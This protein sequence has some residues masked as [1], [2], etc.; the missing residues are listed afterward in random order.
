ML[1]GYTQVTESPHRPFLPNGSLPAFQ[2]DLAS[3]LLARGP[4]AW[5][6]SG[7]EGCHDR[8]YYDGGMPYNITMRPEGL[9]VDYGTPIDEHCID[10]DRLEQQQQQQQE[11]EAGSAGSADHASVTFEGSITTPSSSSS[12]SGGSMAPPSCVGYEVT[13]AGTAAANGCYTPATINGKP[14][15]ALSTSG[16]QL[17]ANAQGNGNFWRIGHYGSVSMLSYVAANSSALPPASTTVGCGAAWK[18]TAVGHAP[19][20]AVRRSGL[21]PVPLPGN[22]GRFRREWTKATVEMDCSIGKYGQATITMKTP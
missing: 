4:Y 10:L 2:Q 19:C 6:G 8:E 9:D 1:Y 12:S 7:W 13:G 3:F 15:F 5:L 11:E 14:G 16:Y 18:A 20:P 22:V 21:G 17:Y